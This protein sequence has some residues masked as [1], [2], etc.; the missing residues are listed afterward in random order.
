M[1]F[2]AH[3]PIRLLSLISPMHLQTL[4]SK[5]GRFGRPSK[6]VLTLVLLWLRVG[7][8]T[9]P[10]PLTHTKGLSVTGISLWSAS[11]WAGEGAVFFGGIVWPPK[12]PHSILE[13]PATSQ[14]GAGLG[15]AGPCPGVSWDYAF[16]AEG[17]IRSVPKR[18]WNPWAGH[19]G[20]WGPK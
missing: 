14:R 12:T 3:S 4:L 6:Q 19:T 5:Q 15:A 2:S 16:M 17:S 9:I 20:L 8:W 11:L 7:M 1:C 10:E 18:G 13:W